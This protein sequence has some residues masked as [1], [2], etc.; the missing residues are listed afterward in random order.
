MTLVGVLLASVAVVAQSGGG[1]VVRR[2]TID[3]GG[4][5]MTGANGV[6][7]QGTIGQADAGVTMT[8]AN[9]YRLAG[10]FWVAREAVVR[11]DALFADGFE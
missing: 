10:G 11:P 6:V 8:G 9:G 1:Y 5:R 4:A 2:Q 7:L 3:A